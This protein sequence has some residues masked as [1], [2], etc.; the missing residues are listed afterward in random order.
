MTYLWGVIIFCAGTV[1]P[2]GLFWWF[3][4]NQQ[5]RHEREIAML[6]LGQKITELEHF[7]DNRMSVLAPIWGEEGK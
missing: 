3:I 2:T 7:V 4:R 5:N 1:A 6:K